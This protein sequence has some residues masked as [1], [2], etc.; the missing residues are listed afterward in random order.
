[1]KQQLDFIVIGA[2]KSG[3]TSLFEY[4]RRHR[5][6]SLP[7]GKEVPYFSHE[8]NYRGDWEDYLRKT[9]PFANPAAKWGTVTP[10]YMVGGLYEAG[11]GPDDSAQGDER[12]VP[13][14]IRERLPDVRLIAILRDPV[15]RAL[16]HHAMAVMNGW[17]HRD[18]DR[19]VHD[20]L[21]PEAL[22]AARC[23]PAETTGYVVWGE[24]GRILGGYLDVF[25]RSQL[26]VLYTSELREDPAAAVRRTYAFLEVDA[27][28]TPENLGTTYRQAGA[29]R[30]LRW[31]DLNAVQ[32][33]AAGSRAVRTLWRSI[34][35]RPRRRIDST[36]DRLN[37][38]TDLWNRRSGAN[39]SAQSEGTEQALRAH[40]ADDAIRLGELLGAAPSRAP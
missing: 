12:T 15:E 34:P 19:A 20:L 40:Y 32:E 18:F 13:L 9:F 29:T 33:A 7:A 14:R 23:S 17:E 36:F 8:T 2:Q 26:L 6:I 16:S 35:E 39:P 4:L 10:H 25:P 5:D 38:L 21:H 30:R 27:D 24:Y 22:A 3:T 28:F 31:L 11:G 37:Y 1:M